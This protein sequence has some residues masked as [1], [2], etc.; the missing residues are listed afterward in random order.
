MAIIDT[1]QLNQ[2][3]DAAKDIHAQVQMNWVGISAAAVLIRTELQNFNTWCRDVADWTIGHGGV[4]WI[5]R[6]LIWNPPPK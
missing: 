6:K 2:A 3:F 4:G 1:N 5:I